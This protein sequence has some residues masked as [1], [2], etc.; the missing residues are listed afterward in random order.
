MRRLALASLRH[1]AVAF[2]AT[3]VS[4]AL[5]AL[6]V[7]SFAVLA[8]AS[9][10]EVSADD[11]ETLRI[12]GLVVGS[13]GTLIVVASVV[14][15]VGIV[16]GQRTGEVGLLRVIGATPRQVR[17]LIRAETAVL[18]TMAAAL[19]AAVALPAGRLLLR[20]L[21]DAGMVDS[22]VRAGRGLPAA[23]ATFALL[24]AASLAASAV[25]SRRGVRGPATLALSEAEA[26]AGRLRWW[27][28]LIG[29]ALV[30]HGLVM[31]VVTV[32]V[33]GDDPD[34]YAAMSTSGSA[35]IVVG[36]GLAC[37]APLLLRWAAT[38]G[39]P[40]L[41]RGDPARWLA[42][43][44]ASRRPHLLAG[45]LGPVIVFVAGAV[46]VLVMV[47]IDNRTIGAGHPEGRTINLLNN[48]VTGMIVAFAAIMVLN[49]FAAVVSGRRREL[50]RLRLLG[51][52]PSEVTRSVLTEAWIVALVGVAL[53]LAA[54]LTTIVPFALARSEGVVPD[55]G[56]WLP[57]MLVVGAVA[58]TLGSARLALRRATV[59]SVLQGSSP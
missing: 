32:T 40:L 57:P 46:G 19:G 21:I 13:W 4:V 3:F 16:V 39:A 49:A 23:V 53:G 8:A 48:L 10:G 15:T 34:P 6:L 35:S 43:F 37:L 28:L 42:A 54:A 59:A 52:T 9:F 1:R 2:A 26:G 25:A 41:G 31:A 36:V 18:T 7:G 58:L 11:A 50:A 14:S 27:R 30:G 33:T 29:L 24:L 47:G 55:G 17:R 51:A 44:N 12:M 56:L 45:V 38:V 22:T 5:G 20:L